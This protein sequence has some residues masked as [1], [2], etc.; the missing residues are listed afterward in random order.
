M[1]P[2]DSAIWAL[3]SLLSARARVTAGAD[4]RWY[5]Q[6]MPST[7]GTRASTISIRC[8]FS[9]AMAIEVPVKTMPLSRITNSTWMYRVLT[10]SVSLVTRETSWP[11]MARSKKA[12]GRRS[13]WP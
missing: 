2:I 8:Q 13:T 1:P 12:I 7:A 3:M 9:Q 6:T 5:S 11:V 4:S 10:A